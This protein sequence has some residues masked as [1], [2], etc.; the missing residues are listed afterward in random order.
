[1][2][3]DI[4]RHHP[5]YATLSRGVRHRA[6]A[7]GVQKSTTPAF[8]HNIGAEVTAAMRASQQQPLSPPR[9]A[10]DAREGKC[11]VNGVRYWKPNLPAIRKRRYLFTLPR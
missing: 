10:A 5:F 11:L 8:S 3:A 2:P 7:A 4:E 9:F 6:S 1:M